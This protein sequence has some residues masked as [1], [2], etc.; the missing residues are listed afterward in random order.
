MWKPEQAPGAQQVSDAVRAWHAVQGC[1]AYRRR[2]VWGAMR[3][4]SRAAW[5]QAVP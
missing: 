1:S 4:Q 2:L 3:V 5:A